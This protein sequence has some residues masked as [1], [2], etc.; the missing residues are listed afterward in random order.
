MSRQTEYDVQQGDGDTQR[1]GGEEDVSGK[2]AAGRGLREPV[3]RVFELEGDQK[4]RGDRGETDE[5][6][7]EG[8][9]R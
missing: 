2:G 1:G 7:R 9:G 3:G 5:V 8:K 4:N 6:L